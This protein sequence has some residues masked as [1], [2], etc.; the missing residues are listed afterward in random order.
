MPI[1]S[2]NTIWT[3]LPAGRTADTLRLSVFVS[4]RVI[5][6]AQTTCAELAGTPLEN[7]PASLLKSPLDQATFLFRTGNMTSEVI[8][9]CVSHKQLSPELWSAL[10]PAPTLLGTGAFQNWSNRPILSFSVSRLLKPLLDTYTLAASESGEDFPSVDKTLGIIRRTTKVLLDPNVQKLLSP[11]MT[12]AQIKS[13][14]SKTLAGS[15]LDFA[16]EL[17]RLRSFYNRPMPGQYDPDAQVP[18]L[19]PSELEFHE[20]LNL[21]TDYPALLRHLGLVLDFELPAPKSLPSPLFDNSLRFA[22]LALPSYPSLTHRIPWTAH[23]MTAQGFYAKPKSSDMLRGVLRLGDPALFTTYQVDADGAALKTYNL[24]RSVARSVANQGSEAF[25]ESLPAL[26]GG[27]IVVARIDRGQ[28]LAQQLASSASANSALA[29]GSGIVVEDSLTFH[30]EDLTRGY[31]VDVQDL[32]SKTA[33][34][35]WFSLCRRAGAYEV[36][37]TKLTI[38]QKTL[39]REGCVRAGNVTANPGSPQGP[40]YAHEALFGWEGWSL[41]VPRPGR[42]I[43]P[44]QDPGEATPKDRAVYIDPLAT[45][46]FGIR[47][48]IRVEPKSLPRLRFGRRYRLRARTVDLAGNSLPYEATPEP[49]LDTVATQPLRFLR[50]EPIPPPAFTPRRP[51]A[52][53]ESIE[54]LVIRSDFDRSAS[55]MQL[56]SEVT[57]ALFPPTCE[58]HLSPPKANQLQVEFHG[59]LDNLWQKIDDTY[60]LSI[61]EAGNL[62]QVPGGQLSPPHGTPPGPPTTLEDAAKGDPL[63]PGQYLYVDQDTFKIPYL[64]DPLVK[65]ILLRGAVVAQ[66]GPQAGSD[67]LVVT[68]SDPWPDFSSVRLILQEAT[69]NA[70]KVQAGAG[71]VVV[72]LPKGTTAQLQISCVPTSISEM[73]LAQE[74]PSG[75]QKLAA[76]GRHWMFT[77]SRTITLVHAVQRPLEAPS[78]GVG[79]TARPPG[80]KKT[81]LTGGLTQHS[82]STQRIDLL[83]EWEDPVDDPKE[84]EPRTA[85]FQAVAASV[86]ILPG[87]DDLKI[88]LNTTESRFRLFHDL[89]DTKA[90]LVRY[91]SVAV[92]RFREYFPPSLFNEPGAFT[93]KSATPSETQVLS[94]ARPEPPVVAY[95]VPTFLWTTND[96]IRERKAQSLRIYLERPWFSSG[97]G[98]QLAVLVSPS[99]PTG[100]EPPRY[101]SYWSAD[102]AWNRPVPANKP[103]LKGSFSN[104]ELQTVFTL[105]GNVTDELFPLPELEL[106]SNPN[107]TPVSLVVYTPVFHPERKLWYVDVDFNN[108]TGAPY[109]FVRLQVARFQRNS[110][111]GPEQPSNPPN[112]TTGRHLSTSVQIDFVQILP[113]RAVSVTTNATSYTVLLSGGVAFNDAGKEAAASTSEDL[114]I[115]SSYRF[116]ARVQRRLAGGTDLDWV[117][118]GAEVQLTGGAGGIGASTISGT[119]PRPTKLAGYEY[120]LLVQEFERWVPDPALSGAS[121]ERL[122]FAAP[123]LI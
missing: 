61:R 23:D 80:E 22:P 112:L 115:R 34:G 4:P 72:S 16:A 117:N 64:P 55:Q 58:R 8:G 5:V 29:S 84:P 27:G 49:P 73:A 37:G 119:V 32:D 103:L 21:L 101:V 105:Q 42:S 85:S 63:Q 113:N 25:P 102:P 120:R 56:T 87:E 19:P 28:Q 83:A 53:G 40:L 47:A 52:E 89:G 12:V 43:A 62:F 18:P 118:S 33:E 10:F 24:G 26:R 60:A 54:H 15:D 69:N 48:D 90:R 110:I 74:I 111:A 13:S 71:G 70:P 31:R 104:G 95:A 97:A 109:V 107:A 82:G 106:S 121:G 11:T 39:D 20:I 122:V 86:D 98:E 59:F 76:A 77:P 44:Y 2:I 88:D 99:A 57:G 79:S 51:V 65:G 38:T 14:L 81:Q 116:T 45:A 46:P 94:S 6:P 1:T 66:G 108:L 93:R 92:S 17:Y 78:Q 96:T 7:W 123:F 30:A 114:R 67:G 75:A 41:S 36:G 9:Q 100:A 35:Q 50:H 68:Y 3:S 91:S